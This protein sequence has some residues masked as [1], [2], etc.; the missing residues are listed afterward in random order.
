MAE[1][2]EDHFEVIDGNKQRAYEERKQMRVELTEYI[3][4]CNT[5]ELSRLYDE[6]KR[7]RK[8]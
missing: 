1:L 5:Y 7:I 4:K 6:Y 3:D 8:K 2:N